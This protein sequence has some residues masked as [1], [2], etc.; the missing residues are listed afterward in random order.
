MQ[1]LIH[2]YNAD[3]ENVLME[4]CTLNDTISS[5]SDEPTI[6]TVVTESN[7]SNNNNNYSETILGQNGIQDDGYVYDGY[8]GYDGYEFDGDVDPDVL[9]PT[10]AQSINKQPLVENN[11]NVQN[12]A[13]E[14]FCFDDNTNLNWYLQNF[15]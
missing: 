5:S 6:F 2:S 15:F 9:D 12:V 8:D 10:P 13:F 1:P 7:W 14:E 4:N 3:F 11:L